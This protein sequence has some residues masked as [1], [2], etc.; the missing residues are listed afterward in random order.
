VAIKHRLERTSP[1]SRLIIRK[2]TSEQ[3]QLTFIERAVT[4]VRDKLKGQGYTWANIHRPDR[5]RELVALQA[6][7]LIFLGQIQTG[8]DK[9]SIRYQEFKDLFQN[10]LDAILFE[11]DSNEDGEPDTEARSNNDVILLVR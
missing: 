6:L 10:A 5:L 3:E 7:K 11:Y 8:N 9:H 2:W 4:N 1:I